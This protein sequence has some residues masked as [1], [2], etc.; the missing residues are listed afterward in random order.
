MLHVSGLHAPRFQKT[1][2]SRAMTRAM[3]TD[4]PIGDPFGGPAYGER[5]DPISAIISL[6][7]MFGT[8]AA[9]GSFAAMTLMQG[10]TFAGA[11]LSLVGNLT[12]NK[13]LSKIGMVAGIAGG[14]GMLAE[15]IGNFTI[16]NNLGDTFGFGDAAGATTGAP[17]ANL[18][19]T[20]DVSANIAQPTALPESSIVQSAGAGAPTVVPETGFNPASQLNPSVTPVSNPVADFAGSADAVLSNTPVVSPTAPAGAPAAPSVV[21]APAAPS[22]PGSGFESIA[23]PAMPGQPGY[24]W[25]YFADPAAGSSVAISPEGKYFLNGSQVTGAGGGAMQFGDY[26]S[27]AWTGIKDIGSGFMD[28]AK[29]NPGAAYMLG[30]GISS[31]GDVLSGKADAQIAAMEAQGQLSKAQADK[32]RFEMEEYKRRIAQR[33]SNYVNVANPLSNWKPDFNVVPKPGGIITGAMSGSGAAT[34]GPG[35]GG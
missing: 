29:S 2:L 3:G 11:A 16:G 24:N 5:N 9:A 35:G 18:T 13:T 19:Q 33:N 27:Q 34:G 1:Y 4:H 14:V 12:G 26:A 21:G 32:L 22:V 23:N 20:P 25:D 28:L 31:V 30:Q 7:S 15:S 17:G 6:G 8:Y 10:L